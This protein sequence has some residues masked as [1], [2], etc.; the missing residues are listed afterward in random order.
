[1]FEI[2]EKHK[3]TKEERNTKLLELVGALAI[4]FVVGVVLWLAFAKGG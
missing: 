2:V 3:Q 1:M 4:C